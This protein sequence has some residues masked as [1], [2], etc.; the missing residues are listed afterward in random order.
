[1]TAPSDATTPLQVRVYVGPDH[2]LY[3]ASL[4]FSGLCELE[5]RGSITLEYHRPRRH[6]ERWLVG[7]AVVICVDLIGPPM[8]RIAIDLRDGEGVSRPILDRV[9]RYLKRAFHPPELAALPPELAA[10][11]EPYGLNFASRSFVSTVRLLRTIGV[12]LLLRGRAG[13]SRLREYL[14]MPPIEAFEQPPDSPIEA[15]ITYQTRLWTQGEVPPGEVEE[16]NA[17]RVAMVRSLRRAFGQRFIGG[18][19]R[20][21]LA[22]AQY[23]DDLTPHSSKKSEYI[24]RRKR[25]LVSV[26]TRGIEHSLAFKLGETLAA[27]QCLVSAPLRFQL[28]APLVERQHYLPF[29]TLDQCVDACERLLTSPQLSSE[30]RHANH[31]YYR[32][33]VEPA[34]HVWR[35]LERCST[36]TDRQT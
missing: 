5:R 2:D 16:L 24:A 35:V 32:Q 9:D 28:P 36:E 34:A 33:E 11:V 27:S 18:L 12:P 15:T 8:R 14:A 30:M 17:E 13:W 20:T 23:P 19:I 21:P 3:H 10:K 4:F 26:Y 22:L 6:D 7:D 31:E 25:C 29:A 1:L